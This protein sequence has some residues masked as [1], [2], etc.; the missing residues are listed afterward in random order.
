M[1]QCAIFPRGCQWVRTTPRRRRVNCTTPTA[2]YAEGFVQEPLVGGLGAER[3]D[4]VGLPVNQEQV[5][6]LVPDGGAGLPLQRL[7]G[8]D[9]VPHHLGGEQPVRKMTITGFFLSLRDQ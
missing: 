4:Q 2:L 8:V 5:A 1:L 9:E 6:D 3:S 7:Q